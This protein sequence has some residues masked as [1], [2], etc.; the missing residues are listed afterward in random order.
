MLKPERLSGVI[1]WIDFVAGAAA[2]DVGCVIYT[3]KSRVAVTFCGTEDDTE[4]DDE[5]RHSAPSCWPT[6]FQYCFYS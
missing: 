1:T 5:A 4:I 3:V 6:T 2:A